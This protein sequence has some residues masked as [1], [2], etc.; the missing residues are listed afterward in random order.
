M[1]K[2]PLFAKLGQMTADLKFGV[3]EI[4]SLGQ[5]ADRADFAILQRYQNIESKPIMKRAI[6]SDNSIRAIE[7]GELRQLTLCL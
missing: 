3:T 7:R 6:S 1:T 5:L 2:I 4:L